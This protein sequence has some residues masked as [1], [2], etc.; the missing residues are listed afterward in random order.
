MNIS[1]TKWAQPTMTY[2]E[3]MEILREFGRHTRY[4]WLSNSMTGKAVMIKYDSTRRY[5]MSQIRPWREFDK[6]SHLEVLEDDSPLIITTWKSSP[7]LQRVTQD[8][9]ESNINW[10]LNH[11]YY[12]CF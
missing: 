6:E 5:F 7:S 4:V 10:L 1:G 3:V 8:V 9:F 2:E 11:G 12:I